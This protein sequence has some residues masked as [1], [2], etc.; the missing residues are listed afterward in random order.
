MDDGLSD[1]DTQIASEQ[2]APSSIVQP[3]ADAALKLN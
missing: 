1:D 3:D 2:K